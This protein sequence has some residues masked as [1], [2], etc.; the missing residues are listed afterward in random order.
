ML[1]TDRRRN[2][3]NAS[4]KSVKY[5]FTGSFGFGVVLLL[6]GSSGHMDSAQFLFDTCKPLLVNGFIV[7]SGF[8]SIAVLLESGR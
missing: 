6:C 8:G 2:L 4:G 7:I 5:F 1:P 3:L